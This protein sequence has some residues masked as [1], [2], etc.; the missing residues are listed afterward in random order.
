MRYP[1]LIVLATLSL[2][3]AQTTA[4][5]E[6][7]RH[8]TQPAGALLPDSR[9][10]AAEKPVD[11]QGFV[12]IGGIQQWVRI[13]GSSCA[14]PIVLLVHGGPGNPT[15]PFA[16]SFYQSW[17]QKFTIVQWDQRGAGMT[18]GRNPVTDDVPLVVEQ[19]RDDGIEVARFAA[20][21]FGKRQVILLGGSWSSV[22]GVYMAK[23][24]PDMF[25]GYISTAQVVGPLPTQ[26]SI[27]TVLALARAA[28]DHASIAKIEALGPLPWTNP[29]STGIFRRVNRQYEHARTQAIP[30][31]WR[32]SPPIYSTPAYQADYTA[33]ED[34]SW[35]QFVGLK[36]DGI[37][38]KIDLYKLGPKFDL[39][40]YM[41]QG[42]Q[43]L[44]TMPEPSRRYFDFIQ[45][46]HKEY[47]MVPHSGHDPNPPMVQTQLRLLEKIGACR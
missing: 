9:C 22:L 43:D 14:N 16:D 37:A 40:F 31:A 25:C 17:E 7:G 18:Y 23:A 6:D 27:D 39:P 1:S 30:Q 33:G 38:S 44:L 42:E 41:V 34:Y 20:R 47:V 8:G 19:L 26:A 4:S 2:A 46:P 28:G 10:T 5:A 11:E 24:A 13:K 21:R 3:L 45:A 12:L 36:G 15:T 29:R 35:L 32:D